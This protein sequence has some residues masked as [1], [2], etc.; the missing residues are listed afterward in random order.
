[1][2]WRE[3]REPSVQAQTLPVLLAR[4]PAGLSRLRPVFACPPSARVHVDAG[5]VSL[6]EAACP[7]PQQNKTGAFLPGEGGPCSVPVTGRLRV[8]GDDGQ[9]S[10]RAM[11][12]A[13]PSTQGRP[14]DVHLA[15]FSPLPPHPSRDRGPSRFPVLGPLW[16]GLGSHS[17]ACPIRVSFVLMP[18]TVK[19]VSW[20]LAEPHEEWRPL[21]DPW[22]PHRGLPGESHLRTADISISSDGTSQVCHQDH[23]CQAATHGGRGRAAGPAECVFSPVGPPVA[24]TPVSPEGTQLW[25]VESPVALCVSRQ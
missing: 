1:M 22:G 4:A 5:H 7:P 10:G 12:P 8:H 3:Q 23:Q 15:G 14:V 17:P 16:V 21:T 19:A 25:E 20:G 24:V 18:R 11:L 13:E 9:L 6:K 2:S